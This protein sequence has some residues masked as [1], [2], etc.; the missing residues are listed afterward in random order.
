MV[1]LG[2]CG[3][4]LGG[5]LLQPHG[6]QAERRGRAPQMYGISVT[7]CDLCIYR[8]RSSFGLCDGGAGF[9]LYCLG[10][11][12]ADAMAHGKLNELKRLKKIR[13]G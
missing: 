5:L 9:A 11:S 4:W 6:I 1:V 12:G 10:C 13:R 8:S 2:W 7:V 3:G